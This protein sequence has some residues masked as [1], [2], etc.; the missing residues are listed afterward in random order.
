MPNWYMK[1]N[2]L[3]YGYDPVP[4]EVLIDHCNELE[5]RF[6]KNQKY[7]LVRDGKVAVAVSPGY[8]AGWSTWSDIDAMDGRL[9]K[10]FVDGERDEALNLAEELYPDAYLGGGWRVQIVWVQ[11]GKQFRIEEYDGFES[12]E[13]EEGMQWLTA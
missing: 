7:K 6:L 10:L 13:F 11:V 5:K 3:Y 1:N 4:V 8:G 12:I 2:K 9:N